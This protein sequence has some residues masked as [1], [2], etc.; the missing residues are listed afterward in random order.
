MESSSFAVASSGLTGALAEG[1][2]PAPEGGGCVPPALL[3]GDRAGLLRL[4][5]QPI[6][7]RPPMTSARLPRQPIRRFGVVDATGATAGVVA[8]V[9]PAPV[10]RSRPQC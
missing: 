6:T 10:W 7:I 2:A 8:E 9:R 4:P 5:S 3:E 1:A